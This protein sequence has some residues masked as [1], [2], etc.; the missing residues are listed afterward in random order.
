MLCSRSCSNNSRVFSRPKK[1]SLAWCSWSEGHLP[2]FFCLGAFWYK[3]CSTIGATSEGLFFPALGFVTYRFF[4]YDQPTIY[5]AFP[6]EVI[7]VKSNQPVFP[8][9]SWLSFCA[10]SGEHQQRVLFCTSLWIPQFS[11]AWVQQRGRVWSC[12]D[13]CT[14]SC[15]VNF[16][17]RSKVSP[18][19]RAMKSVTFLSSPF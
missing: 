15:W 16:F 8:L 7:D 13:T 9:L 4:D 18:L 3:T 11:V 14:S 1:N 5:G 6:P 10:C 19:D 2:S 12:R 17:G